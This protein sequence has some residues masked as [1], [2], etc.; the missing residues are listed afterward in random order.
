MS[1]INPKEKD[2]KDYELAVLVREEGDLAAVAALAREHSAEIMA[3][4]RAKKVALSYPIKKEKEAIFAYANIRGLG[5]AVK[6]LEHDLNL[7]SDVLRS[8]IVLLPKP[9]KSREEMPVIPVTQKRTIP[10]HS[11]V[12]LMEFSRQSTGPLSNKALEKKIEEI[13]K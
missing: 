9:G 7:R 3:D 6:S 12:P 1:D 5:E 11:V 4:F 2:P 10:T 13:L 8:L